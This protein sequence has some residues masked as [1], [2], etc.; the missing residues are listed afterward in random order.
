MI[1]SYIIPFMACFTCILFGFFFGRY[2]ASNISKKT[3]ITQTAAIEV[4]NQQIQV[5]QQVQKDSTTA[6]EI[7][8]EIVSYSKKGKIR[9]REFVQT[10]YGAK[11]HTGLITKVEDVNS[12]MSSDKTKNSIVSEYQSN[13]MFRAGYMVPL[14]EEKIYPL[15]IKNVEIGIGYRLLGNLYGDIST[16]LTIKYIKL[17]GILLL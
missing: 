17:D 6:K 15:Q 7:I 3:E 4:K 14:D 13:W 2:T 12:F 5:V 16:N 9:K 10:S 11:T 1:K 8:R